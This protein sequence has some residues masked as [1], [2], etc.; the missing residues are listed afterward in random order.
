MRPP[1]PH[2]V[3]STRER[4]EAEGDA[5]KPPVDPAQVAQGP[6]GLRGDLRQLVGA[7][8]DKRDHRKDQQ[9]GDGQVE[10]AQLSVGQV[11]I[12]VRLREGGDSGVPLVLS[13]PDS[14]A[15]MALRKIADDLGA[16]SRGLA[17]RNLGI[18]PR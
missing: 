1:K 17:G 6:P 11:P 18:T 13:D 16:R 9:L 4:G 8:D 14:P 5:T 10:H 7:E 15:G 12:D 2:E 3:D